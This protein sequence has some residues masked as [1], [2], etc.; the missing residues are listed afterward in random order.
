MEMVFGLKNTN[1]LLWRIHAFILAG[2]DINRKTSA[3]FTFSYV[4]LRLH[5]VFWQTSYG[6]LMF[7]WHFLI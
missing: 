7:C 4:R 3:P 2:K 1:N 6:G 5:E